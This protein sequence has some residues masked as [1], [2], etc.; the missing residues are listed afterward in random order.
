MIK[1][2]IILFT[3]PLLLSGC[4]LTT[5][6]ADRA[7]DHTNITET[8]A[9]VYHASFKVSSYGTK[10]ASALDETVAKAMVVKHCADIGVNSRIESLYRGGFFVEISWICY[11]KA[12]YERIAQ[13][14]A[15]ADAIKKAIEVAK[16]QALIIQIQK[17]EDAKIEALKWDIKSSIF[18]NGNVDGYNKLKF[19]LNLQESKDILRSNCITIE[20]QTT[21]QSPGH[22]IIKGTSCFN[23]SGRPIF[24]VFVYFQDHRVSSVILDFNGNSE[25]PEGM[26][27]LTI[28]SMAFFGILDRGEFDRPVIKNI[29]HAINSKYDAHEQLS[30][31]LPTGTADLYT[32]EKGAIVVHIINEYIETLNTTRDYLNIRYLSND[33]EIKNM[34]DRLG[35]SKINK[36]EF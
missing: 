15:K 16:E 26:N 18:S 19:G 31:Q 6:M 23:V 10:P 21:K 34:L 25:F 14:V 20:S 36:A 11:S 5:F 8:K 24:S 28:A 30:E 17:D 13:E 2:L 1:S 22:M 29:L 4:F 33:N 35:L 27:A 12:Y 32:F 9:G 3:F 7:V